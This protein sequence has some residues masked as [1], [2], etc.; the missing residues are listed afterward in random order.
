MNNKVQYTVEFTLQDGQQAA[1][2]KI[3]D[4][5]IALV[6]ATEQ[7]ALNYQWYFNE[8]ETRCYCMEQYINS[9][10]MLLHLE[11]VGLLLGEMLKISSVT[12]L[13]IFGALSEEAHAAAASFGASFYT[14]YDGF[15]RQ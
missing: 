14:S 5:M 10:A 2:K 12:R 4:E 6:E 15:T 3:V 7:G 9:K 13:E 8:S 1:A 11:N